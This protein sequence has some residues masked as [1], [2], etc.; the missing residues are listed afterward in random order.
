MWEQVEVVNGGG[1]GG[2]KKA[3]HF[4]QTQQSP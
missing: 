4:Q 1:G 2:W 3:F